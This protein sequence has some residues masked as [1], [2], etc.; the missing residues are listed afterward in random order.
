[1]RHVIDTSICVGAL[2]RVPDVER[3]LR[4]FDPSDLVLSV[5]TVAE[6]RVGA[7]L[8]HAPQAARQQ[9]DAFIGAFDVLAVTREIAERAADV[10][11][12]LRRRGIALG[13]FDLLIAA[14]ALTYDYPIITSDRDFLAVPGLR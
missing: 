10:R 5:I 6:L 13:D 9:V 12:D 7:G 11:V 3:R 4:G 1:M 14:T 2:R 8:V